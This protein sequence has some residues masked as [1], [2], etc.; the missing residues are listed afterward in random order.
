MRNEIELYSIRTIIGLLCD[1]CIA[2]GKGEGKGRS[3]K[4]SNKKL[5][6]KGVCLNHFPASLLHIQDWILY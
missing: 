2:N 4:A 6:E 5:G 1:Y 3:R